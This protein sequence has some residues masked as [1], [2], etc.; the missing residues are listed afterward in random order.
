MTTTTDITPF[1]IEIPQADL[2]DLKTRLA[3]TRWPEPSVAEDWTKGVPVAYLR[4]LVD[5]WQTK[6]EWRLQ[7]AVSTNFRSS[8]R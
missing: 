7:E 6:Y 5:Y 1:R 2:D 3:H 8:P 4:D